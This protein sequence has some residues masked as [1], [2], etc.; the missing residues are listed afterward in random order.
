M[1]WR[2][3]PGL[4]AMLIVAHMNPVVLP[5]AATSLPAQDPSQILQMSGA[6]GAGR[7][8]S[9]QGVATLQDKAEAKDPSLGAASSSARGHIRA[10]GTYELQSH[11]TNEPLCP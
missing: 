8:E 9:S 10:P 5:P 2:Q 4:E 6:L 3:A 7:A 1:G 11:L